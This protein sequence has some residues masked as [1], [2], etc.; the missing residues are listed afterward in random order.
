[1]EIVTLRH[2]LQSLPLARSDSP[3]RTGHTL[4]KGTGAGAALGK[5]VFTE[6]GTVTWKKLVG[7]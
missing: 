2:L 3:F 5:G 1:M 7:S 4:T 6:G